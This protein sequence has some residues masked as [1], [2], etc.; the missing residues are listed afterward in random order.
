MSAGHL[1]RYGVWAELELE[2]WALLAW[3]VWAVWSGI[4]VPYGGEIRGTAT[5]VCW[6]K[7]SSEWEESQRAAISR[8]S[9]CTREAR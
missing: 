3:G 5:S 2:M 8:R 1:R 9:K 4:R 6:G 7:E